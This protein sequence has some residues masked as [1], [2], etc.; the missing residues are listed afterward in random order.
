MMFVE[1]MCVEHRL[2]ILLRA[3]E[4]LPRG[5]PFNILLFFLQDTTISSQL[6]IDSPIDT[7]SEEETN[8]RLDEFAGTIYLD[9]RPDIQSR[10]NDIQI[11]YEQRVTLQYLQPPALPPPGVMIQIVY[12]FNLTYLCMISANHY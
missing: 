1:Q 12:K 2:F 9:R 3:Y 6:T 7:Y 5:Q 11:R 4:K 10:R 8:R